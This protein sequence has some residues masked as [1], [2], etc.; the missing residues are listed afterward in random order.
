MKK[1]G[2][3]RLR[4]LRGQ[5]VYAR[6]VKEV[7]TTRIEACRF[8][9]GQTWW[10]KMNSDTKLR[11]ARYQNNVLHKWL[12]SFFGL[13]FTALADVEDAFVE[14]ISRCPN[15]KDGH[16]FSDFVLGTYIECGCLFPFILWAVPPS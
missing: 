5:P 13:P 14:L 4:M 9:L 8:H 15:I 6:A 11:I 1:G 3:I 12:K 16:I 10:H 7:L 2:W